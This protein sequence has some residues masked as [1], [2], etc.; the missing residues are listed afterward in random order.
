M[1]ALAPTLLTAA[2]L[3]APACR[4]D[5][6]PD[7]GDPG[8]TRFA[9]CGELRV[10]A[11]DVVTEAL[12]DSRY[13]WGWWR[14]MPEFDTGNGGGPSDFTTTNV[15]E[16]GVD[17][18]DLVKTDGLYLYIAQDRAL[19]IVRSW[20]VPDAELLSTVELSGWIQGLF[21]KGDQVVVFHSR[22]WDDDLPYGTRISVFDVSD[23][24]AP[25]LTRTID[26]EGWL[27]D[28]RLIDGDVYFVVNHYLDIPREAWALL[29]GGLDLPEIDGSRSGSAGFDAYVDRQRAKARAILRPEV[30]RVIA[31]MDLAG[32]LPSWRDARGADPGEVTLMHACSDI[33]RPTGI[34]RHGALS[35]VNLD[36]EDGTLTATGLL[37]NGW[38]LYASRDSLY[39]SQSS[40]WWWGWGARAPETHIH[41]F[42]L[43]ATA[44]PRYV[45]SGAVAGYAY[46]QFAFSEHAGH[47]RVATSEVDWWWGWDDG[48]ARPG[49]NV[50]VLRDDAAG[51]LQVV[52]SVRDIAPGERIFATRYLGDRAYMVTFELVDPLF[53]LDLSDPTDPRV[54]GE[55]KIPGFSSYLHPLAEG[56]LLA[57]GMDGDDEGRIRGLAF[58][59][60]DVRD[61][62]DPKR[63]RYLTVGDSEWSWSEALWDHHAFTYHRDVLSVPMYEWRST[64]EGSWFSGVISVRATTAEL[65]TIGRVDHRD[66]VRDSECLWA[67][68]YD[69]DEAVCDGDYWYASV[70]RTVYIE[71]NLFSLSNYG[72]KV[73]DLNDPTIERARVLF[74]PR[75]R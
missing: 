11:A 70:R 13:G 60:F 15:Q 18:I 47:L 57:V 59:V 33:Y 30:E 1:R 74:Y 56:H 50:F 3:A 40:H 48:E 34:G 69:Y 65:T 17:E 41:K 37:S 71:D 52:G 6:F 54:V 63:A 19:Q 75:R 21:L 49:N 12:L 32:F 36:L 25:A 26:L 5:T 35:V 43:S 44:E 45:A 39:V 28:G 16:A 14:G 7:P 51:A 67:R 46:D 38:Q 23:R 22:D 55:L 31:G 27:A 64:G 42:A 73:T 10:Y 8:L 68:W 72:V 53:T 20:P 24:S 4:R 66:L 9:D 29:D 62:A 61:P 58:S 2:L